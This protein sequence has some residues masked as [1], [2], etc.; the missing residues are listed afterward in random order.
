MTLI[1]VISIPKLPRKMIS[2]KITM[3]KVFFVDQC[4]LENLIQH[5]GDLAIFWLTFMDMTKI[6]F[7]SNTFW[8][9][10]LVLGDG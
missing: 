9:L 5:G 7:S 6:S 8:K 2:H 1:F 3:T 4:Y 10:A